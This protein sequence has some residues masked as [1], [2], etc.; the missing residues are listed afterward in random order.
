MTRTSGVL[1]KKN[2]AFL[3]TMSRL[4]FLR[5]LMHSFYKTKYHKGLSAL[6]AETFFLSWKEQIVL[7]DQALG[8]CMEI[9]PFFA[10]IRSGRA[11]GIPLTAL[12]VQLTLGLREDKCTLHAALL[13]KLHDYV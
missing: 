2:L 13:N 3:K 9:E 7:I 8:N 10:F 6:N 11:M 5:R 4:L 12:G 1:K